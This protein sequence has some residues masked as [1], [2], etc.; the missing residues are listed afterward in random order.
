MDITNIINNLNNV[1][2]V[3][4][5]NNVNN[6]NHNINSKNFYEFLE[7][8]I[9][10]T[11]FEKNIPLKIGL[12][13]KYFI[14]HSYPTTK[15]EKHVDDIILIT[16]FYIT[17]N[18]KRQK[19]IIECLNKN[20]NNDLITKIILVTQKQFTET[21][22]QIDG[23][24]NN[25][26]I[27]Q[28]QID[29]RMKYNDAFKIIENDKLSGYIIIA[30]SDIFF[31][32]TLENIYTSGMYNENKIYS[33]LRFEYNDVSLNKCKLFGPRSDSQDT[34]MFHSNFNVSES[35]RKLFNFEL[36]I[37]GCD[38][39]IL[40]IFSILGY[41]LHNDPYFIKTYHYHKSEFRTYNS[42]TP[43]ISM[44]WTRVIPDLHNI[45]PEWPKPNDKWWRFNISEENI[46]FYNYLKNM[47]DNKKEFLIPRIAGI[48]NNV[49]FIGIAMLQ[50]QISK[51][52]INYL[53]NVIPAM[54]NNAGIK[55]SNSETLIKYA[56]HYM[57]AF[58]K[59]TAF[60][61]WDLWGNYY[62]HI[63]MSYH[64]MLENF[65]NRQRF[66][67]V[68]LDIFHN[69]FNNPWTTALK[70]KRLL[71]VSPLIES[72]KAK[73]DILPEIYGVDLFPNCKF[74]F[75]KPP[76]TQGLCPSDEFDK[77]LENFIKKVNAIK[78]DFDIALCS[79]GGYGNLVC[80]EIFK[81][82]KSAIYVGGV[83]QMFFGIYGNRWLKERPDIIRLFMNKH[84]SRPT[85]NEKPPGHKK[86]EGSC[87][88]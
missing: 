14:M 2:N 86:I 59:S 3:S 41:K 63:S 12:P 50:N 67:S 6:L 38:N 13:D 72:M 71:I 26:K 4:K 29:K 84:W 5:V 70:G 53:N 82:G 36:G 61:D 83:L 57:E 21:E 33:Q 32:D 73:L 8:D 55:I 81:L 43:T 48:E 75:L 27:I 28:I 79:C 30:N 1:N 42:K 44:P 58:D 78:D 47:I 9:L 45:I 69:I 37:P 20:V 77:E 18:S 49:A 7:I 35:H 52:H 68:T 17:N 34:W 74:I 10:N 76:Q 88:W 87:Y 64:F 56:K 15:N 66:W 85:E 31:D 23:N 22:M 39:H 46:Q 19:E 54:K 16:Q 11:L 40:Y 24:K 65:K 60:F 51:Q 62:P 25:N 80:L